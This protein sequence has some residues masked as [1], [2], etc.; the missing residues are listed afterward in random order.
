[1]PACRANSLRRP[2]SPAGFGSARGSGFG[3]GGWRLICRLQVPEGLK[4]LQDAGVAVG[5]VLFLEEDGGDVDV[6][7]WARQVGFRPSAR[8]G[9]ALRGARLHPIQRLAAR[10][11]PGSSVRGHRGSIA[12]SPFARVTGVASFR[13]RL[14]VGEY[15]FLD[16]DVYTQ[17]LGVCRIAI[18]IHE[19]GYG[20]LVP[21][22]IFSAR[23]AACSGWKKRHCG[24]F[25]CCSGG[26]WSRRT[27]RAG[28]WERGT[29]ALH[30]PGA[31]PRIPAT[32]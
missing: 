16:L 4:T 30:T 8:H 24:R 21:M 28:R 17:L 13:R 19:L 20:F 2:I 18:P 10:L 26:S 25:P 1:M 3:P 6:G 7:L 5:A 27:R 9:D 31:G 23:P 12:Q 32:S 11:A 14:D 29:S 22:C 15:L